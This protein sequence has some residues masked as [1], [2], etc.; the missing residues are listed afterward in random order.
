MRQLLDLLGPSKKGISAPYMSSM[1]F[2]AHVHMVSSL[3]MTKMFYCSM[4]V[5]IQWEVLSMPTDGC[6]VYMPINSK[7]WGAK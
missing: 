7:F 5:A 2:N 6:S 3:S 1:M 4:H